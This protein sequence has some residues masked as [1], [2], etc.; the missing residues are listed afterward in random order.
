MTS[1]MRGRV[2]QRQ[3]FAAAA[4]TRA[5]GRAMYRHILIPTDGSELSKRAVQHGVDLAKS[6]GAQV[7]AMT[8]STPFRIFAIEPAAV[9]GTPE[10]YARRMAETAAKYLSAVK[11]AASAAPVTCD[12]V[13]VEHEHP[14]QAIIETAKKQG[15]DAIVMASHGRRGVSAIVL[16]SETLKVLTHS[17]IPVL[18]YR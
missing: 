11:D 8:V 3:G 1:R 6:L 13:H 9:T 18:V 5:R 10:S 7:T 15:C 2:P 14:Y 16:G 4:T 17:T 12:T